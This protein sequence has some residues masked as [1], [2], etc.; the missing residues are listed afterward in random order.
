MQYRMRLCVEVFVPVSLVSPMLFALYGCKLFC[1]ALAKDIYIMSLWCAMRAVE[2]RECV[3]MS[4]TTI[5][6]H[7]VGAIGSH[8]SVLC[9]LFDLKCENGLGQPLLCS[10]S[11]QKVLSRFLYNPFVFALLWMARRLVGWLWQKRKIWKMR[12]YL[13]PY[14]Y[15]KRIKN[16]NFVAVGYYSI[17]LNPKDYAQIFHLNVGEWARKRRAKEATHTTTEKKNTRKMNRDK[18]FGSRVPIGSIVGIRTSNRSL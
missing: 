1:V 4:Q 9:R 16:N 12:F 15:I 2:P 7:T 13:R 5:T 10:E 6:P 3:C 17:W 8:R 11:N 14:T 18:W